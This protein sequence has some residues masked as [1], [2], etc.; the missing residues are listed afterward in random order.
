MSEFGRF[1]VGDIVA[2]TNGKGDVKRFGKVTQVEKRFTTKEDARRHPDVCSPAG[3]R[4]G[5][6]VTFL[7]LTHRNRKWAYG[8][9]H[10][11]V[12]ESYLTSFKDYLD[13]HAFKMNMLYLFVHPELEIPF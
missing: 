12:D 1:K 4:Y 7:P 5:D 2:V 3:K 9:Q 11:C 10:D 13:D 6:L 8:K